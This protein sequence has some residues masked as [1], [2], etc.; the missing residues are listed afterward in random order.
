MPRPAVGDEG[1]NYFGQVIQLFPGSPEGYCIA[2]IVYGQ[3]QNYSACA[4]RLETISYDWLRTIPLDM[5]NE[6]RSK[7]RWAISPVQ[8]LIKMNLPG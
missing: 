4:G 7:R 8:R 6:Q 5:E 3:V 1:L 2:P